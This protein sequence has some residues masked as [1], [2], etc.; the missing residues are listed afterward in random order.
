MINTYAKFIASLSLTV[1]VSL[2]AAPIEKGFYDAT[3]STVTQWVETEGLVSKET[4]DWKKDKAILEDL[5]QM[6]ESEEESLGQ[7]IEIERNSATE[8]DKKR[9]DIL[10]RKEALEEAGGLVKA[11]LGDL[12]EQVRNLA[13]FFPENFKQ[14]IAPLLRQLPQ[15]GKS[16]R[17]STSIRLRNVIG[18]LSQA[19]KFDNVISLETESRS[20][21]D[22][23]TK[24]V[25]TLYFGFAIA[26]YTDADGSNAGYGYPTG[27]GWQWIEAPE[28]SAAIMDAIAMY[29]KGKQAEFVT[30]PVVLN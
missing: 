5:A 8:S 22:G 24:Q 14:S 3:K 4:N 15:A 12:E 23:T 18:I 27:N 30:L 29:Q 21:A 25:K 9:L 16:S 17:L 6:L 10:A 28:S 19:N 13:P 20:F 2:W 7:R 26:Y 1:S 11:R